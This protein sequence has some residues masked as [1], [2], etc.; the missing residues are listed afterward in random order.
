MRVGPA[1]A[2]FR[3]APCRL[4][5]DVAYAA[6]RSCRAGARGSMG[7]LFY[8][9][10]DTMEGSEGPGAGGSI[11]EL[12]FSSVVHGAPLRGARGQGQLEA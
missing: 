6:L 9:P 5:M 2:R 8:S 4:E 3:N 11:G 7:E 1:S 10:W 12:F